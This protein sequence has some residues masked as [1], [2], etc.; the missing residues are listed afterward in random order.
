LGVITGLKGLPANLYLPVEGWELP[1]NNKYINI[2]RYDL[3][4]TVISDIID[5]TL[6]AT[7]ELVVLKGGSVT[8]R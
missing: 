1:F 4:D 2:T 7:I 6:E 5:M 3:P 8:G